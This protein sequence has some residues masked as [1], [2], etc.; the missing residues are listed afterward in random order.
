MNNNIKYVVH[1]K[2]LRSKIIL[3]IITKQLTLNKLDKLP[4][5]YNV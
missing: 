2:P 5:I 3:K 4:I 1:I